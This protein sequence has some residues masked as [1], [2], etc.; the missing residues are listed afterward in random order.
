MKQITHKTELFVTEQEIKDYFVYI[1]I[2]LPIHVY[3]IS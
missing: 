2:I 3:I 1:E